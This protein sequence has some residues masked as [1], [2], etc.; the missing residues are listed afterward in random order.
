MMADERGVNELEGHFRPG[1]E[2]TLDYGEGTILSYASN[3]GT[4]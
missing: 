3:V 1:G 2:V 4:R